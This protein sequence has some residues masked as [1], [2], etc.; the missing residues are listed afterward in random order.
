MTI[1]RIITNNIHL[2]RQE[3]GKLRKEMQFET[4]SRKRLELY[5]TKNLRVKPITNQPAN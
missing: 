2:S 3:Q 5:V 4:A 1:Y